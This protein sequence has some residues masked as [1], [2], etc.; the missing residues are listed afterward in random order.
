MTKERVEGSIS[1]AIIPLHLVN[2]VK[3]EM[4]SPRA[5]MYSF[6]PASAYDTAWA[7]MIPNAGGRPMFP[8][9]L[10]WI[11]RNQRDEGFWGDSQHNID[12]LTATL[13]CLLALK[14]WNTG[15]ANVEKGIYDYSYVYTYT[16]KYSAVP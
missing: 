13:A 2:R 6:L 9:C 3:E 7:A 16:C 4:L 12:C 8:Q 1:K 5:D 11:L 14:S 15:H 10:Q